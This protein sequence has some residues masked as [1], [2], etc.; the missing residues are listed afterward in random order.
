M[1]ITIEYSQFVNPTGTYANNPEQ[2]YNYSII[3]TVSDLYDNDRT[4]IFSGIPSGLIVAANPTTTQP[5]DSVYID[6]TEY[7]DYVLVSG[8]DNNRW[9]STGAES[10]LAAYTSGGF[11]AIG[12][13][14]NDLP[15]GIILTGLS[16]DANSSILDIEFTGVVLTMVTFDNLESASSASLQKGGYYTFNIDVPSSN[17]VIFNQPDNF[18]WCPVKIHANGGSVF[19]SGSSFAGSGDSILLPTGFN[20]YIAW[21]NNQLNSYDESFYPAPA[22][23]DNDSLYEGYGWGGTYANEI[24]SNYTVIANNSGNS[25][26]AIIQLN[27]YAANGER[28]TDLI[29]PLRKLYVNFQ[30]IP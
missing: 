2:P 28:F 16:G 9:S 1:P 12:N 3:S 15:V 23:F 8:G 13:D 11:W 7:N 4:I 14:N 18:P 29:P 21:E 17:G 20:G 6:I 10:F 24:L 19:I 26:I 5:F 30:A 22:P 27:E 25:G